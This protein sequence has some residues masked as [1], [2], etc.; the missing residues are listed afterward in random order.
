MFSVSVN[1]YFIHCT[2]YSYLASKNKALF[3]LNELLEALLLLTLIPGAAEIWSYLLG[4]YILKTDKIGIIR[5]LVKR[6]MVSTILLYPMDEQY[7]LY[8][9]GETTINKKWRLSPVLLFFIFLACFCLGVIMHHN[10]S[11]RLC[12]PALLRLGHDI[13]FSMCLFPLLSCSLPN[14]VF[15]DGFLLYLIYVIQPLQPLATVA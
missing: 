4:F 1:K 5:E 6:K 10:S 3:N 12:N 2:S 11:V 15:Q 9:K 13:P 8:R 14:P 7:I